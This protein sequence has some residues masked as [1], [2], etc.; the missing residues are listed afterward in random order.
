MAKAQKKRAIDLTT[1]EVAKRLFPRE[2][3][4]EMK[5]RVAPSKK[6]KPLPKVDETKE[7]ES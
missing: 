1:D 6:R 4:K 3:I 2:A 5:K 7:T